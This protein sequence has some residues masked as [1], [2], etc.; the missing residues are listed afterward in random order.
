MRW[1][2]MALAAA[3]LG[4]S[5]VGCLWFLQGSDLVHIEPIACVGDS[6]PIV[7]RHPEWQVAGA[8]FAGEIIW[9]TLFP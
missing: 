6:E 9:S 7:G 1:I 2:W 4:V 8:V 5:G 3:G